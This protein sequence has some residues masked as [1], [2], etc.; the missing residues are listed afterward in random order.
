MTPE[1]IVR[2]IER[3]ERE[4]QAAGIPQA[5]MD[6]DRTFGSLSREENLAHA[7]YLCSG[8]KRFAQDPNLQRKTGSHLTA[9]QMCLSNA[10][11]Y[12]LRE[13]MDHNR[14]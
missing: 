4:L 2:L 14:P 6:I 5:R 10:G 8:V 1:K 3:Y 7:H 9:V 12:T 13:L 11:W